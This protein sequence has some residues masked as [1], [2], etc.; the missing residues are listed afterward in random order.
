VDNNFISIYLKH[1]STIGVGFKVDS[2]NNDSTETPT[3]TN[4][5]S[6]SPNSYSLNQNYPN[7]F[8]PSTTISY[9]LKNAGLT[10]ISI[11][12]SLGEIV[13]S[14]VNENQSAGSHNV[15]FS[16]VN[17]P[18]GMYFYTLS[19]GNFTQTNKMILMK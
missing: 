13:E 9:T 16:A 1:F 5:S 15:N 12:N 19:C 18:S 6:V 4:S 2:A 14:L 8:N 17:L 7:P 11:Y 10:K 3:N